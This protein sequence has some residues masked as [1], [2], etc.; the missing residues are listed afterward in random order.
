M[1][2]VLAKIGASIKTMHTVL[3][4]GRKC[5]YAAAIMTALE[6]RNQGTQ[7][8]Y[9]CMFTNP[10]ESDNYDPIIKSST[11]DLT[12]AQKEELQQLKWDEHE[13][14]ITIK[15]VQKMKIIQAYKRLWLEQIEDDV[16]NFTQNMEKQMLDHIKNKCLSLTN[17]EKKYQLKE[18]KFT[19][20]LV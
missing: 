4:E 1:R 6:Y 15:D 5:G 17:T 2:N 20:N 13:V 3:P 19:W 10:A 11:A 7:L 16:I 9:T 8:Y 18:T 12:K 14:N